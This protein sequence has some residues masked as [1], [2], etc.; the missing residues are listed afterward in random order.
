MPQRP[1]DLTVTEAKATERDTVAKVLPKMRPAI[2]VPRTA[3]RG[4]V[5]S[6][7]ARSLRPPHSPGPGEPRGASGH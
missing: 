3:S 7:W 4:E 5:L 6:A 1:E 2:S